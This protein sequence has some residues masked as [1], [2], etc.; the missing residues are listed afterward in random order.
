[1]KLS[2]LFETDETAWLEIM[3]DLVKKRRFQDLDFRNLSEY[4]RDMAKRDRR[5]VFNRLRVLL[6]HLLKWDYQPR[7]RSRSWKTTI[8]D[9]RDELLSMVDS[10]TLWKHAQEVLNKVYPRAV[11]RAAIETGLPVDRFPKECPYSLEQI[12]SVDPGAFSDN[13]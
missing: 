7:K 13:T 10:K 12:V 6:A 9:Q 1:M 2:K 3:S 4:L 11:Q 8:T 5:E